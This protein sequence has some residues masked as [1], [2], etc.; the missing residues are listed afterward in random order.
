MALGEHDDFYQTLRRRIAAW[1]EQHGKGF[2]HAQI[3]LVA[4][5]LFHLLCRLIMDKRVPAT[6]KARLAA[7]VVYFVSPVD[8]M[9]EA[10][11]G[12]AGYLDDVAV[13]AYALSSL[14][15]AGHGALAKEH[16]AGEGDLLGVIQHVLTTAD[17][18]IGAGLWKKIRSMLDGGG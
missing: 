5:D 18:A 11:L 9:P 13:A 3:L 17:E 2:R 6:H 8:F 15:N 16:W 1:L 10:L 4:P 12:P 7:A 14:V